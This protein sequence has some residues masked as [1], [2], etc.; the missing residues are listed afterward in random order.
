MTTEYRNI[1]KTTNERRTDKGG[2][3]VRRRRTT[4]AAIPSSTDRGGIPSGR[5]CTGRAVPLRRPCPDFLDVPSLSAMCG[6]SD[7]RRRSRRRR[8]PF[9]YADRRCGPPVRGYFPTEVTTA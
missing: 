5:Y 4:W 8:S 3:V 9:E 2:L 7:R 1:K 6:K